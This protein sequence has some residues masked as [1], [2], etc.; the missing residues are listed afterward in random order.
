MVSPY[1]KIFG[2]C[3]LDLK[4]EQIFHWNEEYVTV[5]TTEGWNEKSLRTMKWW[6]F[7][8]SARYLFIINVYKLKWKNYAYKVKQMYR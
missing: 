8:R 2:Y 5:G 7:V 1:Y 6:L 3:L 4:N